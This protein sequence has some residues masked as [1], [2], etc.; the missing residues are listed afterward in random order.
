[1]EKPQSDLGFYIKTISN[2]Y[3]LGHVFN[4]GFRAH[5]SANGE[6]MNFGPSMNIFRR[7][8]YKFAPDGFLP[9]I[10]ERAHFRGHLHHDRRYG[11]SFL[12]PRTDAFGHRIAHERIQ[13]NLHPVIKSNFEPIL[14][15]DLQPVPEFV[16]E[17]SDYLG[18]ST[19]KISRCIIPT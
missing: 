13:R 7:G 8:L 6:A 9:R 12:V 4:S 5:F 18:K 3:N 1:M 10:E 2:S 16:Q 15:N 14:V 11:G 17:I 19:G